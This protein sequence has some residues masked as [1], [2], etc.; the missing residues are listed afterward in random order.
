MSRE[1]ETYCVD[2]RRDPTPIDMRAMATFA[3]LMPILL[4]S[5]IPQALREDYFF[6][7]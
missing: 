5:F 7:R 3:F 1:S 6:V 4:A 2:R